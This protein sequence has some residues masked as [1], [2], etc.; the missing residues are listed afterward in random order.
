MN[1][2]YDKC[3]TSDENPLY[4]DNS[5]NNN[6]NNNLN[7]NLAGSVSN[8][9]DMAKEHKATLQAICNELDKDSDLYKC[10]IKTKNTREI[11]QCFEKYSLANNATVIGI[12]PQEELGNQ[13]SETSEEDNLLIK[14]KKKNNIKNGANGNKSKKNNQ[15]CEES[16]EKHQSGLT[17]LDEICDDDGI[18]YKSDMKT[19]ERIQ[20]NPIDGL[21][22]VSKPSCPTTQMK[23]DGNEYIIDTH[24]NISRW[25]HP[26][27]TCVG[28]YIPD[29]EAQK[30]G[31]LN[32]VVRCKKIDDYN[33]KKHKDIKNYVPIEKYNQLKNSYEKCEIAFNG[34][35]CSKNK[36]LEDSLNI[37]GVSASNE[38]SEFG[39]EPFYNYDEN[40][41]DEY[42]ISNHKQFQNLLKDYVPLNQLEQKCK[43]E[44]GLS[45]EAHKLLKKCESKELI[46]IENHPD[47]NKFVLKTSIPAPKRC[48]TL[49]E[50]PIV[51]HKDI[52]NYVHKGSIPKPK[53][54]EDYDITKHP[55]I[56]K[57]ILK[58][59]IPAPKRCKSIGEYK[60]DEHPEFSEFKQGMEDKC[61]AELEQYA[62]KDKCGALVKC[63]TLDEHDITKHKDFKNYIARSNVEQ[64]E[65]PNPKDI[66][67]HPDYNDLIKKLGINVDKCGKPV[68]CENPNPKDI[69]QHPDYQKVLKELGIEKDKCGTPQPPEKCKTL[70]EY[71]I[72]QHPDYQKV[73]KDLGVEKDKC[74]NPQPP[75]KC[76]TLDEY[77]ITQHKDYQALLNEYGVEKDKCGKPVPCEKPVPP[78]KC[79]TLG[80]FDIKQHPDYQKALNEFGIKNDKCGAPV[81][82]DTNIENNETFIKLKDN[83]NKI[84]NENTKILDENTNLRT[85]LLKKGDDGCALNF[86]DPSTGNPNSYESFSNYE[87]TNDKDIQETFSNNNSV[88]K[89]SFLQS[90]VSFFGFGENNISGDDVQH[91]NNSKLQEIQTPTKWDIRNHKDFKTVMKDYITKEECYNQFNIEKDKC[92]KPIPC[93]KPEPCV[94][95]DVKCKKLEDYNI[96]DHPD[97]ENVLIKFGA[98]KTK[99]GKLV[100]APKCPCIVK[101]KCGKYKYKPCPAPKKCP[102]CKP[103]IDD[104][105]MCEVRKHQTD[106]I[107][108]KIKL[109]IMIKKYKNLVENQGNIE[110][111][112]IVTQK[113][114]IDREIRNKKEL[115]LL[116]QK[117]LN[118]AANKHNA[119]VAK[120]KENFDKEVLR[121]KRELKERD[122]K[123]KKQNEELK[124]RNEELKKKNAELASNKN[125][126]KSNE[127]LSRELEK[128]KESIRSALVSEYTNKINN[129][130]NENDNINNKYNFL[131]EQNRQMQNNYN[132]CNK[133]IEE[134]KKIQETN[135][136]NYNK[137]N[138][139][140]NNRYNKLVQENKKIQEDNDNLKMR[141]SNVQSALNNAK[142]DN[143]IQTKTHNE[144]GEDYL[145]LDAN[146]SDLEK[147]NRRL[148]KQVEYSKDR[149]SEVYYSQHIQSNNY[150]SST[151][152]NEYRRPEADAQNDGGWSYNS[153]NNGWNHSSPTHNE[154]SDGINKFYMP[155]GVN[156]RFV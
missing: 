10:L 65:N 131:I 76:K 115:E 88:E 26:N 24:P 101:D 1:N 99:C 87:N 7:D 23:H 120:L 39:E 42:N 69:T 5:L 49:N 28:S 134:H 60:L 110:K 109:D 153:R 152:N 154:M 48:K 79:K 145:D 86:I 35:K 34:G 100:P 143:R 119:E 150:G 14:S 63:K 20:K 106:L 43:D 72:T 132:K 148:N 41:F 12:S 130:Q 46:P 75:E 40:K 50:Y 141:L 104:K 3:T 97:Y 156:Y 77:D 140:Y 61:K 94:Q 56:N 73:L 21:Y 82:C 44:Y 74:G 98:R 62:S 126:C 51:G 33:I 71:D 18:Y 55:D 147:K 59:S 111:K 53:E 9:V 95:K 54:I 89:S 114:M 85:E 52:V 38:L 58:S 118:E 27:P 125:N 105:K 67:Q 112:F 123:L 2:L 155:S 116:R 68:V 124:R 144:L 78:P 129:M 16:E 146:Y 151:P 64:C 80:E 92:G 107:K 47:I 136:M 4:I 19:Y 91:S 96:E 81:P 135:D 29:H 6:L 128:E 70:A 15:R 149:A 32:D 57:F 142:K 93:E 11:E 113:M 139:R 103:M 13:F 17:N 30:F 22:K 102:V 66:T 84:L 25:G 133:L 137:N 122:D 127:L 8:P 31:M 37:L 36:L 45:N 138:N 90:F 121:M 117:S 83:Y 108:S